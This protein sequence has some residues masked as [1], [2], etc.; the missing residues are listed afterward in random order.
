MLDKNSDFTVKGILNWAFLE[1][2]VYNQLKDL[3]R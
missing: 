1:M 3:I 2:T